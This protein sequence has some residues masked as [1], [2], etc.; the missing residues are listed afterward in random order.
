MN[1]K[2]TKGYLKYTGLAFQMAGVVVF[3]IILG[4]WIDRKLLLSKPYFTILLVGIFFSGFMYKLYKELT[5]T[6]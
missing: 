5:S 1:H 6:E 3:A 2:Q 4:Q